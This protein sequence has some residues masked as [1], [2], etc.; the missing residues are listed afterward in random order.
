MRINA[1]LSNNISEQYYCKIVLRNCLN[2]NT[3]RRHCFLF[4][5]PLKLIT[6]K[7]CVFF[8]LPVRQFWRDKYV[9]CV[10]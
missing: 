10:A 9:V 7:G 1:T 5:C 3:I 6:N 8:Y 4:W 2:K